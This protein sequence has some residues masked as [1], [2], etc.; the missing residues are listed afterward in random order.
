MKIHRIAAIIRRHIYLYQRS[1]PRW[2]E[3]FYWPL[4]DLLLWGFISLYLSRFSGTVPK[5]VGFFLGALIFWD[6]LYRANQG[7][8]ISFL[9]DVWSRNL[10]N[11]FAS[12][13]T[14]GEF[15]AALMTM[16]VIKMLT[17]TIAAV[18][19]AMILYSFNIFTLGLSLIPFVLNLLLMGWAIG[20]ATTAV[21]LRF[22]MGAEVLAWG[23][24]LIFQ[25][26][27]AVFYPVSTLPPL[28][29]TL[30]LCTPSAHVFEGMRQI[31][32]SGAFPWRNLVWAFAL[33]AVYLSIAVTFFFQILRTVRR[34][35]LL[36]RVE[37]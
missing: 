30:A 16:G 22:G 12:P 17:G 25:P 23:L 13:L 31:L 1:L 15:L 2:L 7:V 29:Q 35:G 28:L 10:L 26:I 8:S 21:I 33:N 6:I 4:L 36:M 18:I 3:I 32:S 24:A 5:F 20:I 19:M 34:L 37:Q 27:S 9:E 14:P 11:L